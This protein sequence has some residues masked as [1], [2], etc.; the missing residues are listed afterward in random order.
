VKDGIRDRRGKSND[1]ALACPGR[2]NIFAV[3]QDG[4]DNWKIAKSRTAILRHPAVENSAILE[5]D[6]FENRSTPSPDIRSFDLIAEIVGV[7]EGTL[8]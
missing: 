2:R 7:Y 5:L 1:R 3:Q 4:L 6:A 8:R